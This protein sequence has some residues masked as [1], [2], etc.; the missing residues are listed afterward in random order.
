MKTKMKTWPIVV[1]FMF[2]AGL[3]TGQESDRTKL[4]SPKPAVKAQGN[5]GPVTLGEVHATIE[6]LEVAIRRVVLASPQP[7]VSQSLAADRPATR[8]EII[9]ELWRLYQLAKPRFKFTPRPVLLQVKSITLPAEDASRKPLEALIRHGFIGKVAPLAAGEGDH[10]T[11]EQYGDAL[12][13]FLSRIG[14]LTHTP[15]ARWSPY[16]FNHRDDG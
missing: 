3:A 16:M 1:A 12:G 5:A 6:K 11:V 8:S 14:D 13:F 2:V 7:A 15:S 4:S 9:G 10:L